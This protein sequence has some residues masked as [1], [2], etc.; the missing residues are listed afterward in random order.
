MFKLFL[1]DVGLLTCTYPASVKKEIL[2]M[3][4]D[5]VINNGALFESFVAQE[6]YAAGRELYYYKK[7]SVGEVDFILERED[8]A[9]P[10]EVKSGNDYKKHAALDHLLEHYSFDHAYVLSPHN[11]E[12]VG[13]ITYLPIYMAGLLAR[14]EEESSVQD[15]IPGL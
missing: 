9:V 4:S 13:M 10:V 11:F 6:L 8:R 2:D 7:R 3:N 5:H 1:S 12:S 15:F 14:P